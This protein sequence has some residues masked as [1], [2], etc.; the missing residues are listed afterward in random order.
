MEKTMLF[1]A[2]GCGSGLIHPAPGTWGSLAALAIGLIWG[3]FGGMPLW[4]ILL[5]GVAG[6]YIC[7]SGEKTLG[8][9][10]ASEIV[11]DEWIGMW[12]AMWNVPLILAP[13]AFALFRLFDISK[14]GPIGKI[15]NLNGGLGIMAD[16]VLAGI[17]SRI[18]LAVPIYFFF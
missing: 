13:V 8:V 9:H 18:I 5:A 1:L 11:F 6:I 16:D 4:F 15:Q 10:D 12:I 2:R 7:D 17:I 3:F 14:V